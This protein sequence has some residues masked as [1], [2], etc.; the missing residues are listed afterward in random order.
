[1]TRDLRKYARQTNV[2]LLA[3]F[4]L[5][6]FLIGD[7]LIYIIYGRE[8]ALLGFI[9]ILFGLAPLLLIGLALWIV[10]VIVARANRD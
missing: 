3:G 8:A 5:L 10:D 2:R 6:L 9:C 7:G 1:M 4:I